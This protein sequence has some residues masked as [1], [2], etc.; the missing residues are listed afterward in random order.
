M[1]QQRCFDPASEPFSDLLLFEG[2]QSE[3]VS[4]AL[5][6]SQV[7]SAAPGEVVLEGNTPNSTIYLR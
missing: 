7:L 1:K 5:A 2:A 3:S 6:R 4:D